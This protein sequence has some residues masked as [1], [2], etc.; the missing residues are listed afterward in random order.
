MAIVAVNLQLVVV[1][2]LRRSL[3][4]MA[5]DHGFDSVDIVGHAP[6]QGKLVRLQR[7]LVPAPS[8]KLQRVVCL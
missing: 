8:D 3:L 6:Q 2:A 4:S 5:V 7:R 1:H